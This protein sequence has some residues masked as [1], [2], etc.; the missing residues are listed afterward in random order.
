MK[1]LS[2]FNIRLPI[3]W[4]RTHYRIKLSL[5]LLAIILWLLVVTERIYEYSF[6][7]PIIISEVKAGKMLIKDVPEWAL[8]KFQTS[9]KELLRMQYLNKP[10][11]R[12]DLSTINSE[13]VFPF[14]PDMVVLPGGVNAVVLDVVAPDSVL[15]LLDDKLEL[16][17]PVQPN[18]TVEALSGYTQVGEILVEPDSVLLRGPRRKIESI[19]KIQ[20]IKAEISEGKRNTEIELELVLPS[21]YGATI[22]PSK[23]KALLRI[24]RIGEKEII[25]VAIEVRN[26]PRDRIVL[27]EP[28]SVDVNISGAISIISKLEKDDLDAWIDYRDYNPRRSNQVPI[29]LFIEPEV[30]VGSLLP[31]NVRLIVRRQ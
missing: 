7:I 5:F 2:R 14:T 13:Y 26:K 27:V 18:I 24:E 23:V 6:E 16:K 4:L 12:V 11:L 10:V 19:K 9:G 1:I 20:T 30:E 15:F 8:V 21:A 25:G 31:E 29:R 28:A 17:L 22:E 3:D